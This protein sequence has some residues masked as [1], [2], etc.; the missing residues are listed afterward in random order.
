[1]ATRL[2]P[3]Q[4][5]L[6]RRVE[7]AGPL[8]Q[9]GGD[10]SPAA[11]AARAGFADQGQFSL[12]FQ[13]LVGVTP[14]RFRMPASIAETAARPSKKPESDPLTM[15]PEDRVRNCTFDDLAKVIEAFT[16]AIRPGRFAGSVFDYGTPAG[17]RR[18]MA[19][20]E[21]VTAIL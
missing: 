11:V 20:P 16:D 13:R 15:P 2:P 4:D 12:H 8:R 17:S 5:V 9:R 10:R 3:H 6:A 1:V 19:R 7:R 14:G 21:R 18:A